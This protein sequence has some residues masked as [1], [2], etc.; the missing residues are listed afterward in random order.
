MPGYTN[1]IPDSIPPDPALAGLEG[2]RN[3]PPPAK[4][5]VDSIL[6][7]KTVPADYEPGGALWPMR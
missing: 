1:D 4:E 7:R 3:T 2:I 6:G 5:R